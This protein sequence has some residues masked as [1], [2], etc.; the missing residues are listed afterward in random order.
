[1]RQ[2]RVPDGT[3]GDESVGCGD[4]TAQKIFS[5]RQERIS[6]DTKSLI[7]LINEIIDKENIYI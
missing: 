4:P 1:F 7:K 3:R 6:D 5:F 2:E